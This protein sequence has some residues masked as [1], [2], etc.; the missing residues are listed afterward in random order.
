M[1]ISTFKNFRGNIFVFDLAILGPQLESD[2]YFD[3]WIFGGIFLRIPYA[4]WAKH[5]LGGV[6]VQDG[7]KGHKYEKIPCT[8]GIRNPKALPKIV[9]LVIV[10]LWPKW[11]GMVTWWGLTPNAVTFTS[12]NLFWATWP[13]RQS[14]TWLNTKISISLQLFILLNVNFFNCT[15]FWSGNYLRNIFKGGSWFSEFDQKVTTH[16]LQFF[17]DLTFSR[18]KPKK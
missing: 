10:T 12:P 13:S 2:L 3:N 5:N 1:S 9:R 7:W 6:F 18:Y 14:R 15:K 17:Y 16:D 8:D 11:P 4:A